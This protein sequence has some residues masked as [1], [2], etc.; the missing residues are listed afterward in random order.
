MKNFIAIV[1]ALLAMIVLPSIVSAQPAPPPPPGAYHIVEQCYTVLFPYPHSRCEYV[2]V[3]RNYT[4]APPVRHYHP[5]PP[6]PPHHRPGHHP[7]PPPG[8]HGHHPGPG[9]RR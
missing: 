7:P 6:P 2:R 5:L 4:P 9:P 1:F 8:G 3:R